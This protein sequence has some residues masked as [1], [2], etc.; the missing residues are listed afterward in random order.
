M[1]CIEIFDPAGLHEQLLPL[2]YTR[3]V[4]DLRVGVTTIAQKWQALLPGR[5]GWIT[6]PYLS[7]K[8]KPLAVAEPDCELRLS[9][10]GNVLPDSRLAEAVLELEPG[11]CLC[12][13]DRLIAVCSDASACPPAFSKELL[14]EGYERVDYCHEIRAVDFL[15]DIF[16]LNG[17]AVKSDFAVLTR[18]RTSERLSMSVTV[19]GDPELVFLAPGARAEGCFINTTHGPV[20][21][22]EGA[23]I[24]EGA[25]VRGPLAL[26]E[27]ST[28]LMGAKVYPDTTLGP[29]TKVGGEV[30]NVVFQGYSNKAHDGFLGNAVIG[31]WC[32]L[33]AGCTA[34]NLKNDYTK[35]RLWHYPTRRF[36]RT[37][38]Q[39]CGLIMGDHSKAGINTMF[40]TATVVGVGCNIHGSGFPR[41]FVA[42][43]L[44][45]GTAGFTNVPL[46]K[47]LDIASR[48]M[49]RRGITLSGKDCRIMQAIYET[50]DTY[51]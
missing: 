32:N 51:R 3:P 27:H 19:I 33:G 25:C 42:S 29:W 39:F 20:Y 43:F 8:F 6:E 2:T 26:C 35:I 41:N 15:Y 14:P 18:G 28:V 24:M 45:G 4:G 44:E 12:R 17:D 23:E 21:I 22:G 47:L 38:L 5:Y 11:Q 48:V 30:N 31:E 40:N 37:D 1:N 9:I 46:N 36:M 7:E 16:L 13:H 10:A 50:S 34:S 49:A